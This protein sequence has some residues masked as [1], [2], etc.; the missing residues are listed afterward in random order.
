MW[1]TFYEGKRVVVYV[2]CHRA[3]PRLVAPDT[4]KMGAEEIS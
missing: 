4:E 1:F 2:V 3:E